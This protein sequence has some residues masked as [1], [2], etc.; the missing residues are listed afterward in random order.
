MSD[1]AR[2]AEQYA[3]RVSGDTDDWIERLARFGYAATGLV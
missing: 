1:A 3:N 2:S